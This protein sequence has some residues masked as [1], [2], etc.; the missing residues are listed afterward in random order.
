MFLL[1]PAYPGSPVQRPLNVCVCNR[2]TISVINND[3]LEYKFG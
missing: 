2:L 3:I 1:V